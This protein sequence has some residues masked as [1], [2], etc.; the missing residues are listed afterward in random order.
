MRNLR[1]SAG[2]SRA[3]AGVAVAGLTAG[4]T[5]AGPAAH[6]APDK[7]AAVAASDWLVSQLGDDD[8]LS[9]TYAWGPSTLYG[10]TL[11]G[12]MS[13]RAVGTQ[14][15]MRARML[16]AVQRETG[17]Y[18]GTDGEHYVG[19]LGKLS[20]AALIEGRNMRT[21][22]GGRLLTRLQNRVVTTRN[23]QRGRAMDKSTYGD[24]SSTYSQAWTVRALS[25]GKAQ[26][27]GLA[28]KFLLKQQCGAGWFR[29]TLE[30][31]DYTC[32]TGRKESLS[33]PDVDATALSVFALREARTAGVEGLGD[34]IRDALQWLVTAQRPDGAFVGNDVPNAN[35][36]GLA[37]WVLRVN[38]RTAAAA[39]A[40]E[41]LKE[42]QVVADDVAGTALEGEDGAVAYN[43]AAYEQAKQDGITQG[44]V[45]AQWLLA[46]SQ[47]IP[48]LVS[49]Q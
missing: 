32:N 12:V 43:G 13:M 48:G 5:L 3:I 42:Q 29:A 45:R 49:G 4:L 9:S 2:L 39:R 44:D 47:A 1:T 18:V 10:P 22:A 20:T 40:T 15:G 36:T 23:A 8:L 28:T 33:T 11:D 27:R 17:S 38:G 24:Y 19:A 21:F 26:N 35:S 41:W 37:A 30:S 34:D 25:R 16:D 7:A 31:S 6:A 14:P 46:G